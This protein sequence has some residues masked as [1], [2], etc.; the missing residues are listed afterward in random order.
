MELMQISISSTVANV[1]PS[2]RTLLVYSSKMIDAFCISNKRGEIIFFAP[3]NSK[4]TKGIFEPFLI[5]ISSS[6]HGDPPPFFTKEGTDYIYIFR[7]SLYWS[8]AMG[9]KMIASNKSSHQVSVFDS[10]GPL[11]IVDGL[12]ELHSACVTLCGALTQHSVTANNTLIMEIVNETMNC[13]ILQVQSADKLQSSIYSSVVSA[14]ESSVLSMAPGLF[15]M[16]KSAPSNAAQQSVL[17]VDTGKREVYVDVVEKVW[18][19]VASGGTVLRAEVSGSIIARCFLPTTTIM[20]ITL[21]TNLEASNQQG[22]STGS[23]MTDIE[24]GSGVDASQMSNHRQL[25]L[26]APTGEATILRYNLA[27]DHPHLLPF[28]ITAQTKPLTESDC[29][30]VLKLSSNSGMG[31]MAPQVSFHSVAPPTTATIMSRTTGPRDQTL[32]FAPDTK[33]LTWTIT[34]FPGGSTAQAFIRLV[35]AGGNA[36][37][38]A[39][40]L[41]FEVSRWVC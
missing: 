35:D 37:I 40:D 20:A 2:M 13:G 36:Q 5:E 24:Y 21:N 33:A 9:S 31:T 30:V 12:I 14:K 4:S 29:E 41:E 1:M 8:C 39:G 16:E 7:D 10:C 19:A 26:Q 27:P 32:T 11:H 28:T 18:A 34:Q 38:E 3:F 17:T 23:M 15:G 22:F 25:S 6:A